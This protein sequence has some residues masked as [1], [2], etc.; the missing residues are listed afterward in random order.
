MRREYFVYILRCADGSLYIGVTNNLRRRLQEHTDGINEDSY[1]HG[2]R[3]VEI[4]YSMI[5]S[6]IRDAIGCEKILKNWSKNKKEALIR[7]DRSALKLLS[8]KK[9]GS[10]FKMRCI[11]EVAQQR[12][13]VKLKFRA[14]L[15]SVR[16]DPSYAVFH[17]ATRDDN[18][19]A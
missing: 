17:T 13:F 14:L 8:R 4:V 10:K 11:R 9:F 2:R 5:F 3:P 19:V 18:C 6:D 7:G 1:T 16:A 15:G 12:F